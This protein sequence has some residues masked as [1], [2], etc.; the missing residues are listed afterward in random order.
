MLLCSCLS[1]ECEVDVLLKARLLVPSS[2]VGHTEKNK[3]K[4]V[5]QLVGH[6]DDDRHSDVHSLFVKVGHNERN[7]ISRGGPA[8][9]L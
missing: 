9:A 6:E 3:E 7:N 5:Q 4:G 2:M 1:K 8:N